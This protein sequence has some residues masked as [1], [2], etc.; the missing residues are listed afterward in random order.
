[1]APPSD[2]KARAAA[3]ANLLNSDD[4]KVLMQEVKAQ[5]KLE[6]RRL[7][8]KDAQETAYRVGAYDVVAYLEELQQ[9]H[10]NQGAK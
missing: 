9:Y 8:G 7:I 3:I 1:M 5:F 2:L 4:G 10:T 6:P